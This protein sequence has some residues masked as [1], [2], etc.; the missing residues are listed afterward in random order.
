[1]VNWPAIIRQ[2]FFADT[3]SHLSI[4]IFWELTLQAGIH[5][6]HDCT[7]NYIGKVI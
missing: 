2:V 7:F 4:S 6:V 5:F 1:M 3:V